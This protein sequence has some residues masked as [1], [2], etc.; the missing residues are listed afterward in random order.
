[1]QWIVNCRSSAIDRHHQTTIWRFCCL[2]CC[3]V[4][5]NCSHIQIVFHNIPFPPNWCHSIVQ[6]LDVNWHSII[7]LSFFERFK[8]TTASFALWLVLVVY[9][10]VVRLKELFRNEWNQMCQCVCV[11]HI[12]VWTDWIWIVQSWKSQTIFSRFWCINATNCLIGSNIK[13]IKSKQLT[14]VELNP[15]IGDSSATF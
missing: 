6:N 15:F 2:L 5:A 8:C 14:S 10:F 11:F 1:M 13:K 12:T 7:S 9:C 3:S 4:V